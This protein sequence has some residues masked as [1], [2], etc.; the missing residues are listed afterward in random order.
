M[1]TR[2]E[3]NCIE[4]AVKVM[5]TATEM[6]DFSFFHIQIGRDYQLKQ[7]YEGPETVRPPKGAKSLLEIIDKDANILD[8]ELRVLETNCKLVDNK[9]YLEGKRGLSETIKSS[10]RNL[11][12][13]YIAGTKITDVLEDVVLRKKLISCN[14]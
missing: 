2:K 6:R 13:A 14:D 11:S 9:H 1:A 12:A 3:C 4:N 10:G 5:A 8:R 7:L